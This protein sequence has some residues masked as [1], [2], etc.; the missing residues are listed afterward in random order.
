M[1]LRTAADVRGALAE[2]GVDAAVLAQELERP[3]GRGEAEPRLE[4]ARSVVELLHGERTGRLGD[5]TRDGE[6]L[7]GRT[8][9]GGE[10]ELGHGRHST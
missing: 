5:G 1:V 8:D 10:C 4:R 9:A 6:P 3:V 7:R 2:K